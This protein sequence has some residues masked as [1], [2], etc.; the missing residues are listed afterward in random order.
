MLLIICVN[1]AN[2]QAARASTRQREIAVR[3]ALGAGQWR[4]NC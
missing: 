4:G 2:L 1:I 3:I